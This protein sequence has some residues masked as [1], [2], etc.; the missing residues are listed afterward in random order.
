ML[1]YLYMKRVNLSI[2]V[3]F[4]TNEMYYFKI[5]IDWKIIVAIWYTFE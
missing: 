1:S 5:L 3:L 4:F 2:E